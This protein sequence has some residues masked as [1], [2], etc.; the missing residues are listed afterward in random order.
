VYKDTKPNLALALGPYWRTILRSKIEQV[1][2]EVLSKDTFARAT[3]TYVVVSVTAR[4]TPPLTQR[5]KGVDIIWNEIEDQL[6]E[7][8]D[9]FQDGKKLRVDMTFKYEDLQTSPAKSSTRKGGSRGGLSA[10]QRL[11]NEREAQI[12]A[13]EH[14]TDQP[15]TWRD[16]YTLMRCPGPP[17]PL[18][19]HC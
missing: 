14:S 3:E 15:A 17:C 18:G 2:Q 1:M 10:T 7:W 4:S 6:I 9:H 11:R 8:S 16:V 13:E 5:F 12:N 19:P